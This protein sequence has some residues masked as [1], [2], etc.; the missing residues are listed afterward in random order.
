MNVISYCKNFCRQ[1]LKDFYSNKE[2]FTLN[3]NWIA[4]LAFVFFWTY[5]FFGAL[6]SGG[7]TANLILF[8]VLS[9]IF[10]FL[11]WLWK[12]DK[13]IFEGKLIFKFRD[14]VVFVLLFFILFPLSFA[15][16]NN[17]VVNDGLAHAGQA[18]IH[19]I[20]LISILHSRFGLSGEFIF[21]DL[22]WIVNIC[23][24]IAGIVVFVFL[25]NKKFWTALISLLTLFLL[26]RGLIVVL[27][28]SGG[29][30][31]PFRLFP[32]WLSS[33]LFSPADISFRFAQFFGLLVFG[34]V[35]YK[36]AEKRFGFLNSFLFALASVTIPVLW[37]TGILV[38]QSIWTAIAW[39]VVLLYLFIH[40]ELDKKDYFRLV[41]I[42]SIATLMRQTAFIALIPIAIQFARDVVKKRV[43]VKD[44]FIIA[45][46]ILI[47]M[48][49]LLQSLINGTS[50][51]YS[52]GSA[53]SII[54]SD[55]SGL[56]RVWFAVKSGIVWTA[57]TNSVQYIWLLFFALAFIFSFKNIVRVLRLFGFFLSGLY[58]FYLIH[59]DLWGLGRYQ[60]EYI[61][62]FAILGLFCSM[63]F[64]NR[65][66]NIVRIGLSIGLTVLIFYNGYI[67]K[68][69]P[70]N[71]LS[72]DVLKSVFNDKI[73]ISGEYS[74]LSEFPYNYHEALSAVR[75]AGYAGSMY[76]VG[77]TYGIFPEIVNGFSVAEVAFAKNLISGEDVRV[78]GR[79]L[80]P[81]EINRDK[82][83]TLVLVS[84]VN[85]GE[86]VAE[87]LKLGWERWKNFKNAEYRSTIYGLIR[88]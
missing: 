74:I 33:A 40:P 11:I 8:L 44:V 68:T 10:I 13:K 86:F 67:F 15:N 30:H 42:V 55:T 7:N 88:K 14:I 35:L 54:S 2:V 47:M 41:A 25:K 53:Q 51:T 58:I 1:I 4:I 20:N 72:V 59:P 12:G 27:G 36:F 5:G 46:P 56:M 69:I 79:L 81:E 64:L 48:P 32:L 3:I 38:E 82:R 87:L 18:E 71:N 80:S 26:F 76:L 24:L 9:S 52:P 83:I 75:D 78:R 29:P 57:I 16:L 84:D 85:S 63:I 28:G 21:L 73:K 43:G 49:F 17:S 19:A 62:P 77:S 70:E 39:S 22:V 23:L 37:H 65:K 60:A 34:A 31:P 61:I 45:L 66:L 50:A 6:S